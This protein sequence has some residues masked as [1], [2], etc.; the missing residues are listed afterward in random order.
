METVE[1]VVVGAGV[2]GL[3]VAHRLALAGR[4][5]IILETED[6]FCAGISSRN[7]EVIH[8]GIYYPK[9]SLKARLCVAGRKALYEFCQTRGVPHSRIGKLIV[10]T[11]RRELQTLKQIHARGLENGVDDLTWLDGPQTRE[12][13]PSSSFAASL[14]SPSTGIVDTHA[15]CRALLAEAEAHGATVAYRSPVEG[16][17]VVDDGLT[18]RIDGDA[19]LT[20]RC[21]QLINCAGLGATRLAERIAGLPAHSVPKLHL[22]K[23]SYFALVGRS[24]FSHLIY[25]VPIPGGLGIHLTL[26]LAGQAR[27]GPDVEW[28]D[29]IDYTVDPSRADL[30]YQA[31][32]RYWPELPD[33]ALQP[34]FAGIRPKLHGPTEPAPDFLIQGPDDHG[35]PG[36]VNLFGIESP[37]LTSALAIGDYVAELLGVENGGTVSS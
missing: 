23:G 22:G 17:S 32:R 4:E 5:T 16:G 36:L 8:A 26:D 2:V 20:L 10:A 11:S 30:F 19:P 3:A 6:S 21:H 29:R 27:F 33:G 25:P 35:V 37:G 7:S 15:L 13:E 34:D 1:C 9:N 12:L 24:P 18:L 31:V 14:F 28:V